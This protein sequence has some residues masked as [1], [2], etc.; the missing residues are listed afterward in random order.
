MPILSPH[1]AAELFDRPL[2]VQGSYLEVAL[3]ALHDRLDIEPI[4]AQSVLEAHHRPAREAVIDPDTKIAVIPI[5][6][7]LTHRA[8]FNPA[9]GATG[10]TGIQSM[11]RVALS[12]GAKGFVLDMDT[13]GGAVSGIVETANFLQKLSAEFPVYAVAND[14]MASAGYWLGS[15]ASRVFASPLATVGS[16]GVTTAHI[17]RS[18]E[19]KQKGIVVTHISAGARKTDGSP[20]GPLSDEARAGIQARIDGIYAEFVSHVA[21]ARGIDETAVRSTE[22]GVFSAAQAKSLG[23]VDSVATF[24]EVMDAMR[25][26]VR[27]PQFALGSFPS[28]TP[29]SNAGDKAAMSEAL[30]HSKADLDAAVSA[31]VAQANAENTAAM[32]SLIADAEKKAAAE[33]VAPVLAAITDI[34][35]SDPRVETF[36]EALNDG[37]SVALATKFAKKV[38]PGAAAATGTREA[39]AQRVL[40]AFEASAPKVA[41]NSPEA[42]GGDAPQERVDGQ[43]TPEERAAFAAQFKGMKSTVGTASF[44]SISRQ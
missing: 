13:P 30:I 23:L 16:I 7:G 41:G 43:P 2:L 12:E 40:N 31:A 9:S 18:A 1:L 19:L 37:A 39:D 4:V 33:A 32:A 11:I 5:V 29:N 22:A 8:G 42:R 3:T 14:L 15:T 34:V 28:T 20:F 26:K 44:G 24:S 21:K 6:G 35:G 27:G 38:G 17:D 36:V 10:Y 25:T